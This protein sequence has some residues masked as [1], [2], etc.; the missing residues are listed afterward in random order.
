MKENKVEAAT[1]ETVM[2]AEL[3]KA[4]QY[5]RMD[6]ASR[7]LSRYRLFGGARK[8]FTMSAERLEGIGYQ[9]QH[10]K[11]VDH[12]QQQRNNPCEP[13]SKRVTAKA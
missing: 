7:M 1:T 12:A 6:A 9:H 4:S 10:G 11:N 13:F 5:C 2:M 3:R 8:F